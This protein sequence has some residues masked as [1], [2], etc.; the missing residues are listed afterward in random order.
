[1]KNIRVPVIA[2][3]QKIEVALSIRMR[4][5]PVL[6]CLHGLQ[7]SRQLFANLAKDSRFE[8]YSL[9]CPDL[10]G[11]GDSELSERLHLYDDLLDS[12][13]TIFCSVTTWDNFGC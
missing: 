7:T 12:P 11:F 13:R 8:Q 2:G 6:L 4:E 9:V 3:E 10:V 1:M 5:G